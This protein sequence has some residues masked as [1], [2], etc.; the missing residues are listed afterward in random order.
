MK[1][2]SAWPQAFLPDIRLVSVTDEQP[3]NSIGSVPAS[4]AAASKVWTVI[5]PL[6]FVT[7]TGSMMKR[8]VSV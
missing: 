2:A 4:S 7:A 3:M 5:V 1:L 6:L 8:P